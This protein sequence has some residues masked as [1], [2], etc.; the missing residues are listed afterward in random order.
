MMAAP[1]QDF[2]LSHLLAVLGGAP[3]QLPALAVTGLAL[4]SRRVRPGDVFLALAG[5]RSHGME[6]ADAAIAAGAAAVLWETGEAAP[7]AAGLAWRQAPDGRRV[8]LV[9]VAGLSAR[10]GL[11]A[12]HFYGRPSADLFVA[13]VTGTNGKT[14]VTQLVAAAMG[15]GAC[16]V[17]GTLGHGLPPALEPSGH[18]TPDPVTLH[19]WLAQM[20]E[21]GARAVAMEVSSHALDQDRAAGVRFD[22]AVLTNLTHDHL[23]Y[24]GDMAAYQAAKGRLFRVPGLRHAVVN[25]DDPFGRR[26]LC[27]LPPGVEPVTYGLGTEAALPTLYGHGLRADETGL[28]LEVDTAWGTGT[29]VS[30]LLGRFN[31][32]NLLAA[33]GVLLLSGM[34]LAEALERLGRVRGVPG[35]M[36]CFGGGD[37]PLVVVDYAH[38]PDALHNVLAAL[39]HHCRGRLWC[40]FGCG[41]ERDRAKRPRMGAIAE[42]LADHVVLTD[43]N[44][45]GE[46]PV[47]II[48]EIQSG[49]ADPDAAYVERDRGRAIARAVAGARPGDVVL[50]AGKGHEDYQLAG[51]ERRP[52]S[53]P[54]QVKKALGA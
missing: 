37:R 34:P 21:A 35:R 14:T 42:R 54:A 10:A 33:L 47:S 26:L 28:R 3:A 17:V 4:D 32:A 15:E 51:G 44:P 45:R 22:C 29:L 8:P 11:L 27:M 5:R 16:G 19:R 31:A 49:M 40:V 1:A 9:P 23:D 30:P 46:D 39:R 25:T 20:R 2:T 38:T 53:D 43:D 7:A 18:T 50:V 41:G 52:F 48:E 6:Y 36:E 24:H 12:D 13:G